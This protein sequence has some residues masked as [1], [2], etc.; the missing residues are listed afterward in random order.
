MNNVFQ[1][2]GCQNHFRPQC[3]SCDHCS[4]SQN[5]CSCNRCSCDNSDYHGASIDI[6]AQRIIGAIQ[7]EHI[8]EIANT[9]LAEYYEKVSSTGWNAIQHIYT[10]DAVIACNC[11]IYSGGHEFLN[12]L[13]NEYI[14][15]AN[16]GGLRATW[17]QI[18]ESTM[19]ITEIG[20]ASCRERVF[21]A[22]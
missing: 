16:F 5:H 21:R 6:D 14:K 20:R 3:N 12:A 19:V 10:P 2:R 8:D 4:Q 17:S 22:V 15:R 11:N 13:S 1:K 18:D 7:R 9:F